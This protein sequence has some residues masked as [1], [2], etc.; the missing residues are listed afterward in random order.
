VLNYPWYA[1]VD[2]VV[3]LEQGDF[4]DKCPVIVPAADMQRDC[5]VTVEVLDY[6]VVVLSQSCDLQQRK[7]QLVQVCPVVPLDSFA[8]LSTHYGT[9]KGK[10]DLR[11]GNASGYHMLNRCDLEGF[12]TPLLVADFRTV[13]GVPFAQIERIAKQRGQRRRLLPPYREHLSQAFARF[14]M[15]VGLPSDIAPFV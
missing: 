4:I 13:Y 7:V 3:P 10:E 5:S 1:I 11:R 12:A 6:N 15:R 9:P 14:F 2:G 8:N